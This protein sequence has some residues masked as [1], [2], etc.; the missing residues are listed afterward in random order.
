[1]AAGKTIT[2]SL[3][4][5]LPTIIAEARVVREFP[6]QVPKLADRYRLAEGEG[7]DWNEIALSQ[8]NAQAVTETTVLDNPQQYADLLLT[9]TPTVTGITTI[10]TDRTYKRI[11]KNVAGQMGGVAQ[12]A[13]ERKK[14]EDGLTTLDGATIELG[15]TATPVEFSDFAHGVDRVKIGD[16]NE[17]ANSPIYG[18]LHAYHIADLQDQITAGI[19]TYA[20]PKGFSGTLGGANIFEDGNIPLNAGG[21]AADAKS[22]I[23]ARFGLILVEGFTLRSA[24]KRREEYGG[25]ADQ[26]FIYDEYAYGERLAAGTTGGFIAEILGDATAPA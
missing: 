26:L 22:F 23:F 20:I 5:S 15:A 4:D 14:D 25:G 13:I 16:T 6:G 18:V 12:A 19:G 2:G 10:V 7:L 9:I 21:V 17:P 3:A 24:T 8:M 1:M 11:S